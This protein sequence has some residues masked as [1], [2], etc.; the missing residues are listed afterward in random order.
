M[1]QVSAK[2]VDR[3]IV[4]EVI[5]SSEADTYRYSIQLFLERLISYVVIFG[6]ALVFNCFLATFIFFV[7]FSSLRTF[8]GGIHCNS[9]HSCLVLSSIISLSGSFLFPLIA[10]IYPVYQG[11]VIMSMI[12]V[13]M[14]GSI[15]NRNI[16]WSKQEYQKAKNL[17]R[18]TVGVEISIIFLLRILHTSLGIRFYISYGIVVCAM[19]MLLEIRKRGGVANEEGREEAF[20][21]HQGSS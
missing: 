16:D 13:I 14:I 21:S 1:D 4:G 17:S 6:L 20:D 11:G 19:S 9:F 3:M 18:L 10:K 15:N 8:S 2:I 7:A 12:I 5:S